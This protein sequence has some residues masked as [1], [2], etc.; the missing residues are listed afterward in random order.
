MSTRPASLI[1]RA[2]SAFRTL[3]ALPAFLLVS[4]IPWLL[5]LYA[6]LL[7]RQFHESG[8]NSLGA[9]FKFMAIAIAA[10]TAFSTL[11]FLGIWLVMLT[12]CLRGL[13]T[14]R[15]ENQS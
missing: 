3:W 9:G 2:A 15:S 5:A 4:L 10:M 14:P 8:R 7:S 6:F 1:D 12:R 11:W 13:E